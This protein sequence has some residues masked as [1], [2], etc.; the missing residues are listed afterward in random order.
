MGIFCIPF[1]FIKI[2]DFKS[3]EKEII[4]QVYGEYFTGI[5]LLYYFNVYK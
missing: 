5:R 2:K 4:F 1:A 3:E